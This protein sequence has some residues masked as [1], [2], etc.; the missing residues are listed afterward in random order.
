MECSRCRRDNPEG[1][2]FCSHCGQALRPGSAALDRVADDFRRTLEKEPDNVDARFNLGLAYKHAGRDD[3]A[4]MELLTVR[5][6]APDFADVHV[7]LG[8][9]YLRRGQT[10]AARESL[11]R[12][13]EL[14]PH[15]A[16]ARRLLRRVP[17]P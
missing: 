2:N 10:E 4:E 16:K 5:E 15:H 6:Q 11:T 14:D 13:I 3:L 9:L 8:S 7:E 1:A 17:A 12:A